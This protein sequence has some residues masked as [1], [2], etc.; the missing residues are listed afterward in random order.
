MNIK[1]GTRVP[2]AINDNSL[3]KFRI[4]YCLSQADNS[5]ALLSNEFL[6]EKV[7]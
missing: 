6:K 7:H 4:I 3:R 2:S 5:N 1:E